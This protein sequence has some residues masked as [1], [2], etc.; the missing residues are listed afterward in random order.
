VIAVL[1]GSVGFGGGSSYL[2]ILALLAVSFFTM[3]SLALVCNIIVVVGSTYWFI[4]KGHFK[5]ADFFPF[6]ITSVP[7]AFAGAS[8]KLE[9]QVFFVI[10]G[11]VLIIA[12]IFL[13]WQAKNYSGFEREVT[14]KYPAFIHYIL[15]AG[16]GF[17]SGMVGI[18]G[19]IFLAPILYYLKWGTSVKIAALSSFFILVN[20]I[21]GLGGLFY[22]QTF[23]A[24]VSMLIALG[25]AVLTGGQVG[26]RLS[27]KKLSPSGMKVITAVLVFI[28]GVRVLLVNALNI[29]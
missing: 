6:V 26:V 22:S 3:R 25:L 24:P 19:G 11:G 23:N 7:M 21:S 1:Y 9:E 14:K 17:V 27:F 2:A 13:I 16:I 4:K 10:L 12:A 8:F 5:I 20:S 28:I 15:G 29:L 18:G